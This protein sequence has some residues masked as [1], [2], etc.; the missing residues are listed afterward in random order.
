MDDVDYIAPGPC[1]RLRLTLCIE[2]LCISA[3][4]RALASAVAQPRS[5]RRS[6]RRLADVVER[7]EKLRVVGHGVVVDTATDIF[8]KGVPLDGSQL[9]R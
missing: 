2:A 3:W 7:F 5:Q 1:T 8:S 6:E 9:S 4:A